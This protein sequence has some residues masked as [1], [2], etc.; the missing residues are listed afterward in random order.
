M[1]WGKLICFGHESLSRWMISTAF[2][3]RCVTR[4]KIRCLKSTI[5]VIQVQSGVSARIVHENSAI[6][7]YLLPSGKVK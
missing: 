2:F 7:N 6:P 5:W 3:K 4:Q 1:E